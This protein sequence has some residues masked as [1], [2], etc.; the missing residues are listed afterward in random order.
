MFN[1]KDQYSV[2]NIGLKNQYSNYQYKGIVMKLK[3]II[4]SIKW[5]LS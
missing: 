5:K 4:L 1:S 2:I 3:N